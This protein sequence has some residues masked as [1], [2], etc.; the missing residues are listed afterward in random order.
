VLLRDKKNSRGKK[1]LWFQGSE[2]Q[3][4]EWEDQKVKAFDRAVTF[5]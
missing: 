1:Y 4:L 2:A 5:L 3:E